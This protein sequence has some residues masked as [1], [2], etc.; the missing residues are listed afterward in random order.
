[1]VIR[2][3]ACQMTTQVHKDFLNCKHHKWMQHSQKDMYVQHKMIKIV[4]WFT[5]RAYDLEQLSFGTEADFSSF[6]QV[7]W[8]SSADSAQQARMS[9][10]QKKVSSTGHLATRR[11]STREKRW[12][13]QFGPAGYSIKK[14]CPALCKKKRL[15]ALAWWIALMMKWLYDLKRD[16]KPHA[17]NDERH[18]ESVILL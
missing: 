1:M 14:S 8:W 2:I 17:G 13:S 16:I 15:R 5:T 6:N 11:P 10:R 9:H 4:V 18:S 7:L 3:I 12:R